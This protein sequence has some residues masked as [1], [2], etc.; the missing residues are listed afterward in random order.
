MSTSHSTTLSNL[1]YDP[2]QLRVF[3]QHDG[4]KLEH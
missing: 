3:E 4:V 2:Q 1:G